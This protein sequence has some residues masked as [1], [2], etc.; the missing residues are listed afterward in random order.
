MASRVSIGR[1]AEMRQQRHVLQR[2]VARDRPS[3]RR[4]RRRGRRR[5]CGRSCSAA[6]S[7]ASSTEG[8]RPVFTT[9]APVFICARRVGVQP[10]AASPSPPGTCIE[11]MSIA[12]RKPSS[13]SWKIAPCSSS[14]RQALHVAVVDLHREAARHLR[15]A[16]AR[17]ARS[18][19]CRA[20]CPAASRP[21]AASAPSPSIAPARTIRSPSPARRAAISMQG[22]GGLG[23][24]EGQHLGRVGHD[25]AARLRGR[26]R[27]Y[28][29]CRR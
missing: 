5:G 2:E 20:S 8:P 19:G 1:A 27:R 16:R 13:V 18:P 17:C 24:G 15:R 22:E 21:S 14:A 26:E 25:D 23:G 12:A 4:H 11:S 7:A 9:M 6:T 29:R 28:G 3:A 10:L